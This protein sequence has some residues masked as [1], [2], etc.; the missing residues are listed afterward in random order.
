MSYDGD[1]IIILLVLLIALAVIVGTV[2]GCAATGY[3][4]RPDIEVCA[5]EASYGLYAT[6]LK[7]S[8]NVCLTWHEAEHE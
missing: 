2:S 8:G 7:P 3:S 1:D 6:A 4:P 5:G